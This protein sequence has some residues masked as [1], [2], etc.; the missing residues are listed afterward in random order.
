MNSITKTSMYVVEHAVNWQTQPSCKKRNKNDIVFTLMNCDSPNVSS[1]KELGSFTVT[2]E[3]LIRAHNHTITERRPIGEDGASL[4]V[5]VV[6]SGMQ[7]EEEKLQSEGDPSSHV[8]QESVMSPVNNEKRSIRV[9]AVKGRGF[10]LGKKNLVL[11][12]KNVIPDVYCI[13]RLNSSQKRPQS[14]PSFS[15]RTS[16]IR[17]DTMPKWE[18]EKT[19]VTED[20]SLDLI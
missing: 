20:F 19:F 18:E 1:H 4:E 13:I 10:L 6:L 9:T 15:W 11:G 16:T 17:D 5:R 7:S 8:V 14:H 2:H 3:S 12:K